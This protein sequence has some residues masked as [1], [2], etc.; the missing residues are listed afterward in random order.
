MLVDYMTINMLHQLIS[1]SISDI[2]MVLQKHIQYLPST[3][4]MDLTNGKCEIT[5][6]R[7]SGIQR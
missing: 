2:N 6:E 3:S 7:A 1:N 5:I 4:G